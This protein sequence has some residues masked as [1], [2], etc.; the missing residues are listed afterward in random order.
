MIKIEKKV[1]NLDF[2]FGK[3]KNQQKVKSFL[4]GEGS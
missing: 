1:R 3:V 4:G 2:F